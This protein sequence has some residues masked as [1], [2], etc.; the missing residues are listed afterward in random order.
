MSKKLSKNAIQ[1]NTG[2]QQAVI[3]HL[4][5]NP[6]FC[7]PPTNPNPIY[8]RPL[9]AKTPLYKYSLKT[10]RK[11]DSTTRTEKTDKQPQTPQ[12]K[13]LQNNKKIHRKMPEIA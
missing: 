6:L 13:N 8:L 9:V 1:P 10:N 12:S 4:H 11:G 3:P 2:C 5:P 7:S